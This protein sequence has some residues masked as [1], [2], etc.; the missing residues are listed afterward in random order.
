MGV[1]IGV[2]LII[3]RFFC[4]FLWDISA[5]SP[6]KATNANTSSSVFISSIL[7]LLPLPLR[8][9]GSAWG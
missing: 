2:S 6:N 8:I 4:F 5:N 9:Y 3:Y 1:S 7:E